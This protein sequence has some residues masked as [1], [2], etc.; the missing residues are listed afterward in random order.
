MVPVFA[1]GLTEQR[2]LGPKPVHSNATIDSLRKRLASR[3]AVVSKARSVIARPSRTHAGS[4]I[5]TLCKPGG[6]KTRDPRAKSPAGARRKNCQSSSI[7]P[8]CPWKPES[9][10]ELEAEPRHGGRSM[11]ATTAPWALRFGDK[12]GFVASI[13]R[14]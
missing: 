9:S 2:R 12:S 8:N 4:I 7:I 1:G 5:A 3:N 14:D 11:S 6:T 13:S 10:R